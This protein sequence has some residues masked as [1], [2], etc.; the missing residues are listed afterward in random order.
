MLSR[1]IIRIKTMQVLFSDAIGKDISPVV[2]E[3]ALMESIKDTK[4]LYYTY[5]I[6]LV[7]IANYSVIY[8]SKQANK[9]FNEEENIVI[10]TKIA[11]NKIIQQVTES[12]VYQ[13]YIN[14]NKLHPFIN[15]KI[16]K[17]L[18]LTLITKDK[19]INYVEKKIT[20]EEDDKE[21]LRYIIK[22][23]IGSS[24]ELDDDVAEHF[25]NI[26]DDQYYAL[27]SLQKKLKSFDNK[28]DSLF[29]HNFLLQESKD[30][31]ISFAK[32][33][34]AKYYDHEEE[35]VEIIKPKLK[36]WDI[37]RIAVIDIVMVKMAICELKYFP[38]IPVKVTI[39]EYI[40]LAKEYSSDKSKDFMNGILDKIMKDLQEKGQLR[41]QG[42]G[43][44]N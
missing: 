33:L 2:L 27:I 28:K 40:D 7:E 38:N 9:M 35:L 18:F 39:N 37:E 4:K 5:L 16:V 25:T 36:N 10:S 23:V 32:D 20:T 44:I 26:E 15:K 30:D 43:L 42:R 3:K 13:D 19:Y 41:K 1:R 34:L 17:D 14:F 12:K 11:S 22:K 29:L 31:V 6:Y 21:I 8:S 24:Q